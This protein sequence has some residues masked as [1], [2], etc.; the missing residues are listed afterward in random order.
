MLKAVVFDFNGVILREDLP[1]D[2]V[3]PGLQKFLDEL[4]GAGIAIGI[5]TRMSHEF[6]DFVLNRMN[7]R[8]YFSLILTSENVT[9]SKPDPEIY[10]MALQRLGVGTNEAIVIEDSLSGIRA[11]QAAGTKVIGL[12]TTHSAI[13]L[14]SA[15]KTVSAF[16]E[17]TI[18][19]LNSV[20]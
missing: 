1:D 14:V 11:A 2:Q 18:E 19:M 7:I 20:L 17:L 5:A 10:V 8:Q 3:P 15:N 9:K 13:E 6:V 12:A 4:K 16:H